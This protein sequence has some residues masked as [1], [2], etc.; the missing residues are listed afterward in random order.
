MEPLDA[1]HAHG[2]DTGRGQ[3]TGPRFGGG[4]NWPF[5]DTLPGPP[6]D[7]LQCAPDGGAVVRA[8]RLDRTALR[9]CSCCFRYSSQSIAGTW[10]M[11]LP[12]STRFVADLTIL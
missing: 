4:P 2:V 8:A 10:V 5:P 7:D 11:S 1:P 12:T 9:R 6:T 3:V